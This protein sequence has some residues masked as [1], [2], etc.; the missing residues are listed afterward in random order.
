[1]TYLYIYDLKSNS[2]T[3]IYNKI[4]RRFYYRLNH[5]AIKDQPVRTKSAIEVDDDLEEKADKFFKEFED[6][7]E[8][9]KFKILE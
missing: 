5:S 2:N 7:V 8:L 9:Y 3:R 4:K 1:M 6:Y